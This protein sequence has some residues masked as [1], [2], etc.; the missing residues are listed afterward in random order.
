MH[1]MTSNYWWKIDRRVKLCVTDRLGGEFQPNF[2]GI[3]SETV[4]LAMKKEECLC[5]DERGSVGGGNSDFL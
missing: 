3:D 2:G 1:G 5:S 4:N